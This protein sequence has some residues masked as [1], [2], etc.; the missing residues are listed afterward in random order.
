[1]SDSITSPAPNAVRMSTAT[2]AKV[3]AEFATIK[4][5]DRPLKGVVTAK[6]VN[7][8]KVIIDDDM[9]LNTCVLGFYSPSKGFVAA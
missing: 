4:F 2:L 7:G 3:K 6:T 5:L 8:L 1:M 9:E